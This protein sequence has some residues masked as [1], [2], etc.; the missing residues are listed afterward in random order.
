MSRKRAKS[1]NRCCQPSCGRRSRRSAASC[2]GEQLRRRRWNMPADLSETTS[3]TTTQISVTMAARSP[4]LARLK[5]S[6]FSRGVAGRQ[7]RHVGG[8]ASRRLSLPWQ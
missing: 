6:T 8:S 2:T 4:A 1:I 5:R 3:R 7:Q